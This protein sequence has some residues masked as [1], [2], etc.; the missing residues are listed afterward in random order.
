[1]K[2]LYRGQGSMSKVEKRSQFHKWIHSK[3]LS[4]IR[5]G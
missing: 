5:S 1:M 4:S 2:Q 3:T